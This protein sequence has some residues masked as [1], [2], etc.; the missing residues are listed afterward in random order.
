MSFRQRPG[1][2]RFRKKYA[3][4]KDRTRFRLQVHHS[5][6]AQFSKNIVSAHTFT[7]SGSLSSDP[8]IS[9]PCGSRGV[10]VYPSPDAR[11]DTVEQRVAEQ[12]NSDVEYLT[13]KGRRFFRALDGI[14]LFIGEKEAANRELSAKNG[15][16]LYAEFNP[17]ELTGTRPVRLEIRNTYAAA[18]GASA[19]QMPIQKYA[20]ETW[21]LGITAGASL[22][23][24]LLV[25]L[26]ASPNV[27]GGFPARWKNSSWK[28]RTTPTAFPASSSTGGAAFSFWSGCFSLRRAAFSQTLASAGSGQFRCDVSY[29]PGHA[30]SRAGIQHREGPKVPAPAI[31]RFPTSLCTAA[32]SRRSAFNIY[33]APYSPGLSG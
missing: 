15:T 7:F 18:R 20:D 24:V 25:L 16:R 8:T 6:P 26:P 27:R 32:S 30:R 22:L 2:Y 12:K 17:L 31:L 1:Q 10:E 3:A 5:D 23:A 28:N 19:E 33:S 29:Q 4:P 13:V 11:V 9:I 21:A 14:H